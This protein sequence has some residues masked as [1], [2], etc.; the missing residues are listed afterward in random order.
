MENRPS[1]DLNRWLAGSLLIVILIL[2]GYLRFVGLDWDAEQH[3][4]P[5]ERFLTMVESSLIP[6]PNIGEYFDT[7][8]STL[9]PNNQGHNFYVYGTLPIFMVRY[10]AEWLGFTGYG[11]IYLIGRMLSAVMDL[12]SVVLVFFIGSRLYNKKIGLV[13]AAFSAFAVLQIQQSHFFTVDTFATFF[14]LLAVYFAVEVVTVKDHKVDLVSYLF[15]G[16]ALGMAAASKINAAPV[17]LTL[18]LAGFIYWINLPEDKRES[19]APKIFFYLVIAALVSLISFRIFQPYAFQGPGFFNFSLNENWVSGLKSLSAQTSGD[20]DFPPALQWARRPIWFSLKNMVLWGLGL[21]Y[22]ILAWFGFILMGWK[23]FSGKV[24]HSNLVIWSWTGLYFVWQTLQWNS[25][26]RYQMPIYPLL[27]VFA[28]WILIELWNNLKGGS[29]QL[30]NWMVPARVLRSLLAAGGIFILLFTAGW[31]YSFSRIY[32]IPHPR[33]AATRW[34]FQNIP[35]PANLI[36]D[37]EEGLSQQLLSYPSGMII[38]G[39]SS[40]LT[41]FEAK[42]DGILTAVYF[43]EILNENP[44]INPLLLEI[45]LND[46]A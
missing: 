21:P 43:T 14:T 27:A 16:V 35:G 22:G 18:P 5:D 2:G 3:L 45:T 32:T 6:V 42:K 36:I 44:S 30:L 4:H 10:L 19:L 11:S 8:I 34:M 24:W 37:T 40:W 15:F 29:V 26:L 17:A 28:G 38:Q 41:S 12:L 31:A 9:N 39:E 33:V 7:S 20:V 46:Q 23:I 25:T 1:T 13:G